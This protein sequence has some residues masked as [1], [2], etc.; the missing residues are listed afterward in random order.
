MVG[1]RQLLKTVPAMLLG[2]STLTGHLGAG[3]AWGQEGSPEPLTSTLARGVHASWTGDLN[4]TRTLSWFTYGS[5]DPGTVLEY[6]PVSADMDTLAVRSAPFPNRV[7]GIASPVYGINVLCHRATATGLDPNVAIRYRVG[8][9]AFGWSVPRVLPPAPSAQ[10]FRFCHYG[11]N[12]VTENSQAVVN[13]VADSSPDFVMI[14]GDLAYA[15][16]NQ[17]IWDNYFNMLEPMASQ[18]PV[19]MCPGNPEFNDGYGAGYS[20]RVAMPGSNNL[21]YSF[22]CG[23]V[24]FCVS[25]GGSLVNDENLPSI[26]AYLEELQW[27][28]RDLAE[29]AEARAAGE[30]DFIVFMQ[31]FSLWT[32]SENR[33]PGN[34]SA[35][36]LEEHLLH[37]YGVDLVLVGHDHI[38]QR[39]KPMAYG[40]PVPTGG[41]V[42]VIQGGGGKSLYSLTPRHAPWS[43][44]VESCY[45]FTEYEVGDGLIKGTTYSVQDDQG[46]LLPVGQTRQIDSFEVPT[47]DALSK[48]TI[49][50]L[51][52]LPSSFLDTFNYDE[53]IQHTI[54]RN[55]LHDLLEAHGAH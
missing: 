36:V 4:T 48:S 3:S 28:R 30:I 25:T 5:E 42:Q 17:P 2:G 34:F 39:S 49:A 47:R 50:T 29:A 31:H 14:A 52:R 41:F 46:E 33:A 9:D 20:S 44:Y 45:G 53:M 26:P 6:G 11:D 43:A 18:M 10:R 12:G 35:I 16:G 15:N 27:I 7:A 54:Q 38:Y 8:S 51:A 13:A 22:R 24:H 32:S 21:Y 55:R 1:R 19:M 40:L 37:R 23:P